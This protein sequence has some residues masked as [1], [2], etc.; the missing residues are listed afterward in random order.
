M[1]IA[2]LGNTISGVA[3]DTKPTLSANEKGVIFIET[4]TN[5][6]YQWDTDSW[7]EIV[8]SDASTS[9]KGIAS[10]SSDNF[11][12]SSGAITIKDGGVI[13]GT[14][15][16]GN[17]VATVAGTSNEVNVSGSTG[18]VTIG[19][20]D[21]VT[22]AQDLV[23]TRNLTVS[24][25][26]VTAN[27]NNLTIEDPLLYL[28]NGQSSSPA[29]DSGF[30]VERGNT[31]NVAFIWDES[32]D[33]FATA[34][35]PAN[36]VG[37]TAGNVTIDSYAN[38]RVAT[39]T[40]NVTGNTSGT[41]ATVTGA[42]QTAITSV[43]TLTALQVDNLNLNGNTISSTTGILALDAP[44]TSAIRLNEAGINTDVYIE[45]EN[46][47]NLFHTN[48]ATATVG[49]GGTG[50]TES[51]LA[52][53]A[54]A[55]G[56]NL[57]TQYGT[58][59]NVFADTLQDTG[60]AGTDAIIPT[61]S[62]APITYRT[63]SN[64]R[65]YTDAVS[66]YIQGIPVA[67]DNITFTNT[68]LAL[69]VDAGASRFDGAISMTGTL[70]VDGDLAF[71]GAQAISTSAGGA[72]TITSAAALNL[73]PAAGSV[74]LLDGTISIDAGVVT[75]ATSITST[76]FVGALTGDVTGN[77]SGTAATVTGAA[78][79]AITSLGTLTALQVDNININ[80]NSITSTDSNGAIY[81]APNGTGTAYLRGNFEIDQSGHK[82]V[83]NTDTGIPAQ[84]TNR[85]SMAAADYASG[86]ARFYIVTEA[87]NQ[88]IL[89]NGEVR[90]NTTG[91]IATGSGDLTLSPASSVT[92]TSILDITDATDASDNSGDTGALRTEGGAS[93]AKK[94][95]VGTDLD[96]DGTAELDNITIAGA[97]GNDGDVLTSTGSG[98]GWEAVPASVT[99]SGSTNNTLVTVTGANAMTGEASLTFDGTS[100]LTLNNTSSGAIIVDFD[101]VSNNSNNANTLIRM[102]AKAANDRHA[103]IEFYNDTTRTAM[104]G[105]NRSS[106]IFTDASTGEAGSLAIGTSADTGLHFYTD[107]VEK[108]II[109]NGNDSNVGI[110]PAITE[111]S[112]P[113][114]AWGGNTLSML[115]TSD[116]S[117]TIEAWVNNDSVTNYRTL[118]GFRAMVGSAKTRVAEMT[119]DVVGTS[120][121]AG[122]IRLVTRAAADNDV[123]TRMMIAD[124][125]YTK[126]GTNIDPT[127]SPSA[128]LEVEGAVSI[129][130]EMSSPSAPSDGDGGIL[131]VKTDGKLYYIS[132]EVS[133]VAV[134]D[135]GGGGLNNFIFLVGFEPG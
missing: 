111:A 101:S 3:G 57:Y 63:T 52:I 93:I 121:N 15:T 67:S 114:V 77:A 20:P 70:T 97:Q 50:A 122:R 115:V 73:N 34:N 116:V 124:S 6:I 112:I 54:G 129:T 16:T 19:L 128:Q 31:T 89:G 22:I 123:K 11:A 36:E 37:T 23:V 10:F 99:L 92:V 106:D 95:Y 79:S 2:Y 74:I 85:A 25:T 7:N 62:I 24:G 84:S 64:A 41:A 13:L 90:W 21:D 110:G 44:A 46:N 55:V 39:L 35:V 132:N 53:T 83:I 60:S 127:D 119:W 88:L 113:F 108:M 125:G 26:T 72:L 107:N 120:E 59:I 131:Y 51:M 69:W 45:G 66:L 18:A 135:S 134:S 86:D 33:T 104:I 117:N 118:L 4:D 91:K 43:G 48:A 80:A 56:H 68:A 109:K 12:A 76:A 105:M 17:Y 130:G 133:E 14:E 126:L 9:A 82:L 8:L 100:A 29:F 1:A 5:K 81:I 78:Q 30:V 47:A 87:G 27:V 71:T 61:V 94:L 96:V 32:A 58:A 75:G 103:T 28:A 40:G 102:R 65:T 38:L 49:I 42:A 98:V